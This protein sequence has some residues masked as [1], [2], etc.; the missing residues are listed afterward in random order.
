MQPQPALVGADGA[1][2][3]HPEP[4]VDL[5]LARVVHPGHPELDE[6]LG[7]DHPLEHAVFLVLGVLFADDLEAFEHLAHRLQKFR[8]ARIALFDLRVDTGQICVFDHSLIPFLSLSVARPARRDCASQGYI[9]AGAGRHYPYSINRG[10]AD[11]KSFCARGG[12]F[13]GCPRQAGR[14][15]APAAGVL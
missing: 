4:A 3:L 15:C 14:A 1:V 2:E 5:H 13:F 7:L 10:G 11:C 12:A 6:P 8:F 9:F